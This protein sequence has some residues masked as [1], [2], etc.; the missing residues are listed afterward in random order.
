MFA[1]LCFAIAVGEMCSPYNWDD[2]NSYELY[3]K[4]GVYI[5][6]LIFGHDE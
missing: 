5:F 3:K 1:T 6:A 4:S 2:P